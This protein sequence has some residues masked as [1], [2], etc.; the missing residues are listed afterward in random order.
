[1]KE[2][3]DFLELDREQMEDAFLKNDFIGR[4]TSSYFAVIDKTVTDRMQVKE[5]LEETELLSE[6]QAVL[7]GESIGEGGSMDVAAVMRHPQM[8][9]YALVVKKSLLEWTGSFHET[10]QKFNTYEFLC[11][12]AAE[13]AV[14]GIPCAEDAA[15]EFGGETGS[16]SDRIDGGKDLG[17]GSDKT[18]GDSE[19]IGEE[20]TSVARTFAYI[21]RLHMV[22]L[23]AEGILDKIFSRLIDYMVVLDCSQEFNDVMGVMLDSFA[24]FE[25][26]ARNTAPYLIFVGDDTCYSVPKRFA[27]ALSDALAE[28]GQAVITTDGRHGEWQTG[29]NSNIAI[30]PI[31]KGV[32]GCQMKI[33]ERDL[34]RRMACPKYQFW[35]DNPIY[36]N[37]MFDDLPKEYYILSQDAD[38]ADYIK[39]YYGTLNAIQFPPAGEDAGYA[40]NQDRP[41]DVVFIG[42]YRN[43]WDVDGFTDEERKFYEYMKCH[44]DVNFEE[45]YRQ[46]LVDHTHIGVSD[47]NDQIRNGLERVKNA[48]RAV[49]SYYRDAVIETLIAAGINVHVY[50][51]TWQNFHS[52]HETFLSRHPE[53]S[54]EESLEVFGHAKIGLNIMTWHKAGMTERIANIML[55]GAVCLSDE[56]S[57]LREHYTDG[58]EMLLF[59]LSELSALPQK[60]LGLLRDED[61]RL[62][63]AEKAYE[64][65]RKEHTWRK[66]AEELLVLK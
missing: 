36:F 10:L 26:L 52:E 9:I 1:M 37:D 8:R 58:E 33:L 41:L 56:S 38:Y 54:V 46:Y 61:L 19:T 20:K 49:T 27:A 28:L 63:M 60:V 55:S 34:F 30:P 45:G 51:D 11:R 39:R 7:F 44:P 59:R 48:C 3:L 43:Q 14:Y 17:G 23:Q 66:R 53:V 15:E 24:E 21:A 12:V 4:T 18:D 29:E 47:D 25:K 65:A 50:G 40:G 6:Y 13:T 42:S 22:R 31:L 62:Q 5:I 57:Y 16:G 2:T 64:R 35:F 32:V